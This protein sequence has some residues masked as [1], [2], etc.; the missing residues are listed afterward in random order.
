MDRLSQRQAQGY[1]FGAREKG[2][3][4][5]ILNNT[6]A[7]AASDEKFIE[8][9]RSRIRGLMAGDQTRGSWSRG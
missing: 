2:L 6:N 1:V 8:G 9:V 7:Y 4:Q 3:L 5:S